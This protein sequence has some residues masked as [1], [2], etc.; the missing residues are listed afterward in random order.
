[1]YRINEH[2][3]TEPRV[4]ATK[5]LF[6]VLPIVKLMLKETITNVGITMGKESVLLLILSSLLSQRNN[7]YLYK[8][9]KQNLLSSRDYLK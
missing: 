2:W 5:P 4:F 6:R 3:Y 7:Q 8:S 9:S 1:M